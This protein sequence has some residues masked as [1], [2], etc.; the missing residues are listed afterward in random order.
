MHSIFKPG[1]KVESID[2]KATFIVIAVV[3]SSK[4]LVRDEFEMEYEI[5]TVGL[6]KREGG[7]IAYVPKSVKEVK[8]MADPVHH[9]KGP[10]KVSYINTFKISGKNK[11]KVDLHLHEI[12]PD[13]VRYDPSKALEF[14]MRVFEQS[15]ER[16]LAARVKEFMIVHGY[17]KGVLR[18]EIR[19]FLQGK[20][21]EFMDAD[22]GEYGQGAT[23]CFMR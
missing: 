6:L 14:Q 23:R 12:L 21:L 15:F 16:A 19:S 4:L 5:A 11:A 9:Q 8:K 3:S 18:S 13:N 1:D 2:S 17:G 20:G 10:S 7:G 22:Y